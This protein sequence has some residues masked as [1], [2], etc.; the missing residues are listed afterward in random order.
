MHQHQTST[1]SIADQAFW[2]D[3]AR[4]ADAADAIAVAATHCSVPLGKVD[5]R[6]R[7]WAVVVRDTT[8]IP[9]PAVVSGAGSL[10]LPYARQSGT[11]E[12]FGTDAVLWGEENH[13]RKS[14]GWAYQLRIRDPEDNQVLHLTCGESEKRI[15]KAAMAEG[16]CKM[17]AEF[18]KGAG[19]VAAMIRVIQAIRHGMKVGDFCD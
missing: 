10:G 12:L 15:I 13:H 19:E 8:A 18:L 1:H 7:G 2:A 4:E 16:R 3:A 17:P 9:S 11:E 14:R 6:C 5:S